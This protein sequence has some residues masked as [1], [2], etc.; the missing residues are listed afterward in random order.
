MVSRRAS[1]RPCRRSRSSSVEGG[2]QGRRRRGARAGARHRRH[3]ATQLAGGASKEAWAVTTPTDA[4]CCPAG[5]RRGDPRRHA[6]A[7]AGVRGVS[8]ARDAGVRVP[9]PI[10]YLGELEG[11][12][13]FA[14][15]R[16]HGETI[17]RRIVKAPPPGL[18]S[19]W[20]T[21]WRR[22]TRSRR[23]SC[24]ADRAIW[25]ASTTSWTRSTSRIP[26]SSRARLVRERLPLERPRVV[27]HGDFRIGNVAVDEIGLVAVLDWEFAHVVRPGRGR[28]VAARPRVAVRRG[29][30]ASAASAPSSRTS[31]ATP[32]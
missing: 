18:G 28:R 14:M 19:R 21:S 2:G 5:R 20:R 10:A 4:S 17:G 25:R 11:R 13:A 27:I 26:R 29:R 22:S 9:E 6:V 12:E 23:S 3:E 24:R 16:V 1:A 31:S 7:R 15:E 32:S 8:A 30:G